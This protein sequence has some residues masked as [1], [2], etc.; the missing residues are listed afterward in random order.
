MVK[1][2][3]YGFDAQGRE[4]LVDITQGAPTH[5]GQREFASDARKQLNSQ[6]L[7]SVDT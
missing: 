6:R 4:N 1:A 5:L 7:L 2:T 3:E